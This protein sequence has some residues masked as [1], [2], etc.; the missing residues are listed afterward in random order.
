LNILKEIEKTSYFKSL[1]W[2]AISETITLTSDLIRYFYGRWNWEDLS[3]NPTVSI[4]IMREYVDSLDWNNIS[5]NY[6]E[7]L[8]TKDL[9]TEFQN[10]WNFKT[11]SINKSLT[12]DLIKEFGVYTNKT[13]EGRWN[14]E[15]LCKNPVFVN[16]LDLVKTYRSEIYFLEMSPCLKSIDVIREYKDVSNWFYISENIEML[17]VNI[18]LE[19]LKY[20]DFKTLG[21]NS[22]IGSLTDVISEINTILIQDI[23]KLRDF[24]DALSNNPSLTEKTIIHFS[25]GKYWNWARLSSNPSLSPRV[26][27]YF[28]T[29]NNQY[30]GYRNI[31]SIDD[32]KALDKLTVEDYM[33]LPSLNNKMPSILASKIS[34]SKISLPHI[35]SKIVFGTLFFDYAC[36]DLN[37]MFSNTIKNST[38]DF[39]IYNL[40]PYI[41]S[42]LSKIITVFM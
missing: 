37:D 2:R 32:N 30:M 17:N 3:Q 41:I 24:W 13:L 40:D 14:L 39:Y 10:K 20:W 4:E 33:E 1:N 31:Y 27:K 19:F 38:N 18:I 25:E 34:Y 5:I 21:N 29:A 35:P 6:I 26:I 36:K 8:L 28:F 16:N 22:N 11:L 9:L 12:V 15:R 23:D 7:K 42:D